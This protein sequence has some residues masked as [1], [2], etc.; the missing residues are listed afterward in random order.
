MSVALGWERKCVYY[1]YGVI[2]QVRLSLYSTILE[3]SDS[4]RQTFMDDASLLNFNLLR[5][6]RRVTIHQPN[7]DVACH[8]HEH[9]KKTPHIT[10]MRPPT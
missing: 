4:D 6:D 2:V 5:S 7:T 1:I 3:N 9:R 10:P 8:S